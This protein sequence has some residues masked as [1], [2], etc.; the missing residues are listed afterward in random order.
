M[1]WYDPALAPRTIKWLD[2][3]VDK[4]KAENARMR[5]ALKP[6]AAFAEALNE[7]IPDDIAIGIYADGE[8][9]FGP[10]GGQTVGDLRKARTAINGTH[11]QSSQPKE[12]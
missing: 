9:R 8:M 10:S 6:F 12:D 3:E 2:T 1:T 4:L 7:A 5:A 11:G